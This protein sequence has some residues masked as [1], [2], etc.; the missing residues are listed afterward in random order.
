MSASEQKTFKNM[1]QAQ[2]A[3]VESSTPTPVSSPTGQEKKLKVFYKTFR[4]KN[5]I[6]TIAFT[7]DSETGETHYG[8]SI[9]RKS[10]PTDVWTKR[11][12]RGTAE[13]RLNK[14]PNTLTMNR[15][16]MKRNWENKQ[17]RRNEN[18]KT[19]KKME[20]DVRP[21]NHI[22]E[23]AERIRKRMPNQ[24]CRGNRLHR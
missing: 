16:Q 12:H 4:E 15:E 2:I 1:D 10:K 23:V 18:A 20:V 9:F 24:G 6:R 19:N 13:A 22:R 8:G 17:Q 11:G 21:Y 14:S 5:R 7:N 3:Q